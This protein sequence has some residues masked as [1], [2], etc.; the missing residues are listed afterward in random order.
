MDEKSLFIN[1]SP[2]VEEIYKTILKEL[3]AFGKI[4]IEP[5][6][7][8]IHLKNKTAFGGVHPKKNWLDFNLVLDH[9]IEDDRVT[10][11]EQVSKSRFHNNFRLNS[12]ADVDKSFTSLLKK[13]YELMK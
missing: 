1:K 6:K 7:T 9:S 12:P 11:V 3:K 5:K 13:S 2:V 8:S 10:K 4:I